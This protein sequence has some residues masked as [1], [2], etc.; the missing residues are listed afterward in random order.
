LQ[1]SKDV[2]ITLLLSL[3]IIDTSL[4]VKTLLKPSWFRTISVYPT[5]YV[6]YFI[7]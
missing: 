2:L 5:A 1:R 4:L 6:L 7:L 3:Y